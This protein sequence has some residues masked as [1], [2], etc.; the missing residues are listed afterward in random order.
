[1]PPW[2]NCWLLG[3]MALSFTLH[4]VILYVDVLSVSIFITSITYNINA[5][6]YK[7]KKN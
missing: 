2:C 5:Q 1:M 6:C 7:S 4:F 3:S